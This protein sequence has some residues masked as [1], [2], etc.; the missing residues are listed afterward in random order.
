M[1]RLIILSLVI[2]FPV[3]VF[4]QEYNSM[5]QKDTRAEKKDKIEAAVK[6]I[7]DSDEFIFTIRTAN[8]MVGPSINLNADYQIKITHDSVYTNLP[9]FGE[10]TRIDYGNTEGSINLKDIMYDFGKNFN[11]KN[12][13]Y[14]I[15]FKVINRKDTYTINLNISSLGYGNLRISSNNSQTISYDGI[16]SQLLE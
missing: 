9:Y 1:R 16:L 2:I 13:F 10:A 7:V 12:S 11:S 6:K 3:L 4:S 5:I 15:R 14:E 8:P